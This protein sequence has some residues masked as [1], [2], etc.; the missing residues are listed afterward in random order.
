MAELLGEAARERVSIRAARLLVAEQLRISGTLTGLSSERFLSL[1]ERFERFAAMRN[2]VTVVDEINASLVAAF[3]DARSTSG[4]RPSVSTRHLRRAALRLLFRQFRQ[5]GVMEGDPT[6]DLALPRRSEREGR[7]LT[8]EEVEAGRWASLATTVATRQPAAWALAEAG[9]WT[10]EIGN[11]R[12]ADLDLGDGRVWLSGGPKTAARWVP[13]T[14]WGAAQL[15]RRAKAVE[16]G[17]PLAYEGVGSEQSRRTSVTE[18]IR[19]SLSRAGLLSDRRVSVTSV[20]AWAGVQA[21]R[22]SFRIE[23]AARRLGLDSL[24]QAAILV[25]Y[26]W[27]TEAGE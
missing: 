9:A 12:R 16:P 7:P 25:G 17:A 27:R 10:S 15:A 6:L 22:T 20:T 2:G 4:D 11:V 19:V 13:V 1:W 14:E 23:D 26:D 18:A 3:V 5:L 24:D 21:H 8:D